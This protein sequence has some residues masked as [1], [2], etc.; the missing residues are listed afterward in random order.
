MYEKNVKLSY[1]AA[2]KKTGNLQ[3]CGSL[4]GAEIV[5]WLTGSQLSD[6]SIK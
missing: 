4:E 1:T 5:E 3:H 6:C 2:I